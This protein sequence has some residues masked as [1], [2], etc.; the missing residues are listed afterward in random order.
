M[1][2]FITASVVELTLTGSLGHGLVFLLL[3][4]DLG[5]LSLALDSCVRSR[6]G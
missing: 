5:S 6:F 3:D 4:T 2:F 1:C